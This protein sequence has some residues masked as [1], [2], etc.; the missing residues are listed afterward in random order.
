MFKT[1]TISLSIATVSL[2]AT[3]AAQAASTGAGGSCSLGQN[4]INILTTCDD[5]A[6]LAAGGASWTDSRPGTDNAASWAANATYG[7]LRS[8]TTARAS[9]AAGLA[10]VPLNLV[11]GAE[12]VAGA[13]DEIIFSA[14]GLSGQAGFLN[15]SIRIDGVLGGSSSDP[16]FGPTFSSWNFGFQLVR[17]D[18]S[19]APVGSAAQLAFGDILRVNSQGTSVVGTTRQ[20]IVNQLVSLNAP[21]VFGSDYR[22]ILNL[23]TTVFA[24]A[25][26]RGLP[27]DPS[28]LLPVQSNASAS[29][30]NT[31]T[32]QGIQSVT[33]AN[34]DPVI[35]WSV[36]STSGIDY[37]LAVP[38]PE[39]GTWALLLAGLAVLAGNQHRRRA[40]RA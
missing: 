3:G 18:A 8:A 28:Y 19:G 30:A 25:R 20:P 21:I 29:F 9:S 36:A 5:S 13:Q 26:P 10:G 22:L 39:P 40:R 17:L 37:A 31:A 7:L 1:R 38:V 16:T 34:G 4:G 14:P 27:S 6:A 23:S 11:V 15:A 24:N 32:W 12:S 35:G 2:L 33:L